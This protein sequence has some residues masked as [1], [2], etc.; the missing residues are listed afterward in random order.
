[1]RFSIKW[2]LIGIAGAAVACAALVNASE[3]WAA[4]VYAA[5]LVCLFVALVG[6]IFRRGRQRAFW[7]GFAVFGWG[8]F[9]LMGATLENPI[10]G[11][12]HGLP[13]HPLLMALHDAVAKETGASTARRARA[14]W[15]DDLVSRMNRRPHPREFAKVGHLVLL[16]LFASAGGLVGQ[17]SFAPTEKTSPYR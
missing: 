15:E 5:T 14:A 11:R 7:T 9:L 2:M 13:T 17:Y 4:I 1:M 10:G 3:L 16:L 8:Y 6:A 12:A